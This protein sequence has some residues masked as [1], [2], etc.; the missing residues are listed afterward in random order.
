MATPQQPNAQQ[1]ARLQQIRRQWEQK[2]QITDRLASVRTKIGVYSGKGGV[3]KTTVACNLA[4]TLATQGER[5]GLLDVD[6]DCPNVTRVMGILDKPDYRE[7]QITPAEGHG[8]KVVSMAF[9]QENEDEA[10]IWRG[11]MIHNAINQF[12]Q[13]TDWGELDY[14]I[15]DLPPGTS[16]SPLTVMQ[17]LPMDGF[18]V[19][20]T[21]QDLAIIDAKR[22]INMIRK[23]NLN[24]VGVVENYCGEIFGE[25]AGKQLAEDIDAP[26]L[27]SM[28]LRPSYRDTSQPTVLVD[29]TVGAEYATV[30]DQLRG[31]LRAHGLEA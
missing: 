19:V 28:S 20:S 25:G 26:F 1:N 15:I 30:A 24:V 9:F 14:L 18:I 13:A 31:S 4:T 7:G 2:R 8:V 16:D 29:S 11:P 12:L 17:T 21:P 5:V 23:L 22:C 3:G 6:I 10:I 27:G